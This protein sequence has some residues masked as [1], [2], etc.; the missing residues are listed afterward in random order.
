MPHFFIGIDG[1]GN[2]A[3]INPPEI[4][5]RDAENYRHIARSLPA[6]VGEQLLLIDEKQMQYEAV[7]TEINSKEIKC[8][9]KNSYP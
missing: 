8:E 6:R 9:I 2:N 7:I 1:E 5:I 4:I 3:S